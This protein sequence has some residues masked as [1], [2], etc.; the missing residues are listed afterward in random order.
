MKRVIEFKPAAKKGDPD[1]FPATMK[2]RD[3]GR[4]CPHDAVTVSETE[5][6]VTCRRCNA[7]LDALWVL[8][9]WAKRWDRERWKVTAEKQLDKD[10]IAFHAY[11]GRVVI[12]PSGV[13]VEL[14]GRRWASSCSGGVTDQL[15]SALQRAMQDLNWEAQRDAL[16]KRVNPEPTP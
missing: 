9:D 6:K 12:R 8:A 14:K 4:E 13:A 5:R 15:R 16:G 7:D 10:V 11:G 2:P 3:Y 1:A